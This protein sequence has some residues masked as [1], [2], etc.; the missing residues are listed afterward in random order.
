M[1]RVHRT[2][3]WRPDC[4]PWSTVDQ[5]HGRRS[6]LAGVQARRCT[7]VQDLT[8]VAWGAREGYGDPYPGWHEAAE[9]LGWWGINKGRRR[10]SE[11]DEKVLEA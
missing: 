11:L 1:S 10:Q 4:D 8:V 9:G 6:K 5:S 3:D 2:V 7:R